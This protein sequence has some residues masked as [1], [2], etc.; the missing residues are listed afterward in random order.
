MKTARSRRAIV[1]LTLAPAA[2]WLTIEPVS[3]AGAAQPVAASCSPNGTSLSI[4]AFDF[5]FDKDCLAAPADQP[6]TLDF[7]NLDRGI[8]HNVAI[9]T[10]GSASEALFKGDLVDGPGKTTYSVPALAAGTFFFRCDPHPDM[11]GTFISG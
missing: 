1:L 7:N 11:K 3:S 8:P 6:L 9:Y 2:F 5:K 4:T 10:D